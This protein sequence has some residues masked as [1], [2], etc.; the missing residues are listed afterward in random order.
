MCLCV[1]TGHAR[2]NINTHDSFKTPCGLGRSQLILTV[3]TKI[4]PYPLLCMIFASTRPGEDLARTSG[5]YEFQ[6]R[7]DPLQQEEIT[8]ARPTFVLG[9]RPASRCGWAPA[10]GAD[11]WGTAPQ[12]IVCC[13]A[14]FI[15]CFS[16]L[17]PT[18]SLPSSPPSFLIFPLWE[19]DSSFGSLLCLLQSLVSFVFSRLLVN[20]VT[21]LVFR[22]LPSTGFLI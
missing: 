19:L 5:C 7:G 11:H 21:S 18:C 10:V 8:P 3:E 17:Y 4:Y 22:P 20:L 15:C 12:K 9:C 14:C 13:R 2:L 1:Q 16:S 6:R